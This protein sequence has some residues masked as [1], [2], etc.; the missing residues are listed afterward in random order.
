AAEIDE[1]GRA[2]GTDASAASG[3]I[4]QIAEV[5]FSTGRDDDVG[6]AKRLPA[7][8]IGDSRQVDGAP[9]RRLDRRVGGASGVA[10]R[11]RESKDS[12]LVRKQART[13]KIDRRRCGE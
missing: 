4:L 13:I 7:G 2:I 5:D 12:T 3:V 8:E 10:G 6:D 9:L 11:P 1:A